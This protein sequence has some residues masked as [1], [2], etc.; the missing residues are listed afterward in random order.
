MRHLGEASKIRRVI[1]EDD[2]GGWRCQQT[3]REFR[4][5]KI[6][7]TLVPDLSCNR[8]ARLQILMPIHPVIEFPP[9]APRW[10]ALQLVKLRL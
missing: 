1:R 10:N 8:R 2:G 7:V 9:L 3:V 4:E 6:I 5:G